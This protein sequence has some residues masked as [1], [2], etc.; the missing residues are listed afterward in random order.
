MNKDFAVLLAF[1][2]VSATLNV[3]LGVA[4]FRSVLRERR[5]D[6]REHGVEIGDERL[7][8][9]E[10][11]VRTVSAQV[12][13]LASGQEFLNRILAERLD[14]LARPLPA[15]PIPETTPH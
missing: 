2:A 11:A 5:L 14:R 7:V 8:E 12:E 3:A 10:Q 9:V 15:P 13:Q 4:L 1:F 6:R